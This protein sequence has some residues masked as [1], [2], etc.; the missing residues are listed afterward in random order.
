MRHSIP[1]AA[2]LLRAL[3]ALC[4]KLFDPTRTRCGAACECERIMSD[5]SRH[6]KTQAPNDIPADE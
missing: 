6:E 4:G 3:G 2:F 5:R 1:L